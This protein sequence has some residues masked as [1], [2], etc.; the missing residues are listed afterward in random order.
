[1]S[2]H[3]DT[4][5]RVATQYA[6]MVSSKACVS[7]GR[8]V[9]KG[10]LVKCAGY[11]SE[12]LEALP[13]DAVQNAFGCGNP[14]A[15]IGVKPG[16]TVLDLGAG[17]G[18]DLILAAQRVGPTGSVIGVD[19][20]EAMIDKARKTISE[21]GLTNIEVRQGLIEEMPVD[22]DSVDW[23]I[24]NCVI[25]LSPEKS[26]VFSE[27][28]RVLRPGGRMM[29]SDIVADDLPPEI[30]DDPALYNCCL[31]GAI[32]ESEYRA[33]LEQAGLVDVDFPERITYDASQIAA[34]LKT[35]SDD[36]SG[37]AECCRGGRYDDADT[38][39]LAQRLTETVWSVKI[40]ARKPV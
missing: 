28:H 27:I 29:V 15:F 34:L 19:M 39:E 10:T 4:R 5:A 13:P 25:N 31:A 32:S 17:A 14:L 9:Q 20:T 26:R 1:M 11:S 18:I 7:D 21:S 24:S 23:V 16:N 2:D 37:P 36:S 6:K 40:V 12:E 3:D 35:A 8:P 33:G 22:S 30:R 38:M